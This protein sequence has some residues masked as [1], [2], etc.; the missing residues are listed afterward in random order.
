MQ[1]E[2]PSLEKVGV[3]NMDQPDLGT[4]PISATS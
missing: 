2:N 1:A 3:K 4:N